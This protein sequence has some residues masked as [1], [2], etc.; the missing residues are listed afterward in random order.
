MI[1]NYE[2]MY[3]SVTFVTQTDSPAEYFCIKKN[4]MET[5]KGKLLTNWSLMRWL[6]LIMGV[7]IAFQAFQLKDGLLGILA[8]FFIYQALSNTAC[9][10]AGACSVEPKV[11]NLKEKD[12]L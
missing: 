3:Q 11:R 8:A 5:I 1:D 10:G 4:E 2:E 9:C 12:A 7:I 6:R